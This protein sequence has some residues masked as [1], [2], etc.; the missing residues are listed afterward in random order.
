MTVAAGPLIQQVLLAIQNIL[1]GQGGYASGTGGYD[2]Y[3]TADMFGLTGDEVGKYDRATETK[4]WG[5]AL[6]DPPTDVAA[7]D[8]GA[9]AV[10][11]AAVAKATGHTT[12][13]T[14]VASATGQRPHLNR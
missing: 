9:G 11:V 2:F 5:T 10:V 13:T 8:Y 12:A 3:A 7:W 1:G 4:V 6:S 14:T